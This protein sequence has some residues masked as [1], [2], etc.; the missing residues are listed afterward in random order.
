VQ[1][2]LLRFVQEKQFTPVGSTRPRSVDVR[3][4]AATNRIL[5]QE[6]AAGTFREDLYYRLKV[7]QIE[8]PP[9][10]E[11][12]E[13][14]PL[15]ATHFVDKFALQYRKGPLRLSSDAETRMLQYAWP[16]NVRELQNRAMQAVILSEGEEIGFAEF[17]LDT[18]PPVVDGPP[19][20]V[21]HSGNRPVVGDPWGRLR[22]ALR[23]F[24]REVA[25]PES[26][27]ALPVGKWIDDDLVLEAYRSTEQVSSRAAALLGVAETTFRRRQQ[28]AA[29]RAE[30]RAANRV[31]EWDAVNAAIAGVVACRNPSGEDLLLRVRRLLLEEV[32]ELVR[33][34]ARVGAALMGVTDPTYQRWTAE[35]T[36]A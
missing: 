10:R 14:I 21:A 24:L 12:P 28:K 31:E 15:L 17:G 25:R 1:G 2:K 33:D 9:L 4:V 30:L 18:G 6:V 34:D 11:R 3:V 35:L 20:E 19:E 27:Y 29:A 22:P 32:V 7:I 36:P 16:G 23:E 5:Q 26:G 8:I 13:D